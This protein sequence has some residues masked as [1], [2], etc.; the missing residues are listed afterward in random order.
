MTLLCYED[1]GGEE[2]GRL[3]AQSL[4]LVRVSGITLLFL[5]VQQEES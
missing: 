3:K 4:N 2:V 1:D 5:P